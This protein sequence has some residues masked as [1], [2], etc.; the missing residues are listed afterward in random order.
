MRRKSVKLSVTVQAALEERDGRIHLIV[1]DVTVKPGTIL[2]FAPPAGRSS[3]K[4]GRAAAGLNSGKTL[5]DIILE[6][7]QKLSKK[8]DGGEFS[9]MELYTFASKKY[10]SL[11]KKSFTTTVIASAPE[12]PSWKHYR[13]GRDYLVY[14]G[15]GRYRLREAAQ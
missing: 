10:P 9:S 15:R 12:H 2:L 14:V 3:R 4:K 11:N 8:T 5:H 7:A 13:N 6:T 1:K